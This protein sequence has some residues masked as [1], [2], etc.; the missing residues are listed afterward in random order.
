MFMR[1]GV[2]ILYDARGAEIIPV[3]ETLPQLS[4][5]DARSL[6][7]T[8]LMKLSPGKVSLEVSC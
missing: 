8:R 7:D 2:E 5:Y 4:A 1:P 3:W 6:R